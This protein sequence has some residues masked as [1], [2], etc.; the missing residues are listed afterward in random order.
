MAW[1]SATING[2]PLDHALPPGVQINREELEYECT[3]RSQHITQ[4]KGSTPLGIGCTVSHICLSILLDRLD[5]HPLSHLQSDYGCCFSMPVVLGRK[6]IVRTIAM[7]IESGDQVKI[8]EPAKALRRLI[9]QIAQ[10]HRE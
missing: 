8:L 10:D 2:T 9:E 6:G 5:V 3:H 4:A 1:S 7:P